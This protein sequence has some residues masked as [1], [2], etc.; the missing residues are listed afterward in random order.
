M[1]K[2]LLVCLAAAA[3][4]SVPLTVAAA[5]PTI[6]T[7]EFGASFVHISDNG[8]YLLSSVYGSVDIYDLVDGSVTS[9][10]PDDE[11]EYSFGYGNALTPDGSIILGSTT[12]NGTASYFQNGTWHDLKVPNPQ[13][14]NLCHGITDD[15]SRICGNI[16]QSGID[17]QLMQLPVCWERNADGTYGD[18]NPLPYPTKDFFGEKPQYVTA[19]SISNDGKTIVGQMQFGCGMMTVPVLY[20]QDSEGKWSYSLPTEKYFNPNSL[21]AVEDPGECPERPNAEDYM[22]EEELAKY[23]AALAEYRK[24]YTGEY[25]EAEDYMS[26]EELAKYNADLAEYNKVFEVWDEKSTAYNTYRNNVI[27]D[28]PNFSFNN[29][30]LSTDGKTIVS[31][32]EKMDDSDP[33][34]WFPKTIYKVSTVDIE[35]GELNIPDDIPNF[36]PTYVADN[37][38]ILGG[39]GS[40]STPM[41]GYVY[42]D[43]QVTTIDKYI[44]ARSPEYGKWIVENMSHEV[45]T[46]HDEEWNDIIEEVIYTGMT[47][48]T[49][50]MSVIVFWNDCPCSDYVAESVVFDMTAT[51]GITATVIGGNKDLR[52]NADGQLSVP[53]GFASVE[54]FNISGAV[55]KSFDQPAGNIDLGLDG[56][57][58]VAKGIRND[59][60]VSVIKIANN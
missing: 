3:C 1:K 57:V 44:S 15:G 8:R 29:A 54:I 43:G 2:S 45:V 17:Y 16:G 41:T 19:L 47:I 9:F 20:K 39:N 31:P 22:T 58:Y 33:F 30:L 18:P 35:T 23:Q 7:G 34:A 37:G 27:S 28:S 11:N 46:G 36:A 14:V 55:V 42:Q 53:A 4:V 56:G 12:A 26:E 10:F 24:T 51:S 48:A 6:Y 13:N 32:I 21:E 60:S 49:P 59:G 52:I 25:P 38:I 5:T 40:G 50:D